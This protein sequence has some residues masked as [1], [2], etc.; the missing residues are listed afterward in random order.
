MGGEEIEARWIIQAP[1][2]MLEEARR[3]AGLDPNA[4]T[5]ADAR[6]RRWEMEGRLVFPSFFCPDSPGWL[7][8]L[9]ALALRGCPFHIILEEVRPGDG[10][11]DTVVGI[12]RLFPRM[13]EEVLDLLRLISAADAERVARMSD[14]I[15][16]A[17]IRLRES[18]PPPGL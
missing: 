14:R 10:A 17:F 13:D 1:M 7:K 11:D 18:G 3:Q 4:V 8:A 9:A 15:E 6:S 12:T 5:A 2:E 16:T